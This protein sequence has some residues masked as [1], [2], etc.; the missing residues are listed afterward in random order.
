MTKIDDIYS[1]ILE[2]LEK[3]INYAF[4]GELTLARAESTTDNF[5]IV[6]IDPSPLQSPIYDNATNADGTFNLDTISSNIKEEYMNALNPESAFAGTDIMIVSP[7]GYAM[8]TGAQ[9]AAKLRSAAE[10]ASGTFTQGTIQLTID[11]TKE[12]EKQF[13]DDLG[14]TITDEDDTPTQ[15]EGEG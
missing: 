6:K 7:E 12:M 4:S 15:L 3:D 8:Y 1:Q 2:S 14:V 10:T 13:A 5:N 9:I 11:I